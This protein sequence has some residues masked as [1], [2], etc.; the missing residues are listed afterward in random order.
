M[1]CSTEDKPVIAAKTTSSLKRNASAVRTAFKPPSKKTCAAPPSQSV[2]EPVTAPEA[3]QSTSTPSE[4]GDSV[5]ESGDKPL[6]AR[7]RKQDRLYELIQMQ[8][9]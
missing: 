1:F 6:K 8:V 9:I 2:T 5:D 4:D 7:K 3:N